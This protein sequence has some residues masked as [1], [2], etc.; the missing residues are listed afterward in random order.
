MKFLEYIKKQSYEISNFLSKDKIIKEALF[1]PN[2][3]YYNFLHYF[4]I[5]FSFVNLIPLISVFF[6][7]NLPY[8]FGYSIYAFGLYILWAFEWVTDFVIFEEIKTYSIIQIALHSFFGLFLGFYDKYSHFD[9]LLHITGGIWIALIIFPI[10]LSLELT[11]SR[12]KIPTLIIKV[13]FYTFSVSLA[14]GTIW[15]IFEFTSDLMFAGYPGYRLAQE[16]SLF[17]TMMDLIYDSF[18]SIAGIL[19]FWMLLKR[20]NKNRDIYLLLEKIGLALRR[21]LDKD[22]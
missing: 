5:F 3:K 18:G 1:S 21:F 7:F 9:D 12:Q 16:G 8:L 22:K 17:D 10:I 4:N 14:M 11:F 13:N 15:E 19:I 2:K 6:N 20:L